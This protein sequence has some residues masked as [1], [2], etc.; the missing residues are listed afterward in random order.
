MTKEEILNK[1]QEHHKEIKKTLG[2]MVKYQSAIVNRGDLKEEVVKICRDW[3]DDLK[4]LLNRTN[5]DKDLLSKYSEYFSNLLAYS[6]KAT[7][8]ATYVSLLE[9]ISK[10]YLSELIQIIETSD[11]SISSGLNINPFIDDIEND[12]KEYLNEAAKCAQSGCLRAAI[13]LGWCATINRIHNKIAKEG[14]DKFNKAVLEMKSKTI[15]RFKKFNKKYEISSL[16]E[17]REIFDTDLLLILEYLGYI[18]LN[19]HARLRHCFMMRNHSAHP[20]EAPISGP[21]L[22][23]FYSD[24]VEIVLKNSKFNL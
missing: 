14:F 2:K 10:G 6:K 13:I 20:G 4:I 15:G 24:I 21:N 12:E 11:I 9:E 18:D 23:S 3:F 16:S 8:K 7:R 17:I 1:L 5:L 19:Q 22:Y